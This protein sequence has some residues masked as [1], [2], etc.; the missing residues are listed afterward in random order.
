MFLE[1]VIPTW[2][3]LTGTHLKM[4]V[5]VLCFRGGFLKLFSFRIGTLVVVRNRAIIENQFTVCLVMTK[6]II[7]NDLRLGK[8]VR[9][10]QCHPAP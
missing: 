3:T 1:H 9:Q 5:L 10:K 2:K 8:V 7:V 4:N 6:H